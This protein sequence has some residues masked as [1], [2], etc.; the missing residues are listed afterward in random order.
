[1]GL[2]KSTCVFVFLAHQFSVSGLHAQDSTAG[3]P[4]KPVKVILTFPTCG[5]VDVIARTLTQKLT[6]STGQQYVVDNRAGAGGIV[7][8]DAVA[9]SA[10]DGYTLLFALDT[11]LTVTPHLSRNTPFDSQKDFAPI[12]I[13]AESP[14]VVL[15][16]PSAN[17]GS[18]GE[19]IKRANASPGVLNFGSGGS[20]SSGHLAAGLL[21]NMTGMKITH[22]P[23]KGG[24]QVLT[25]LAG[26]QNQMAVLSLVASNAMIKAGKAQLIAVTGTSWLPGYPD[27]PTVAEAGVPGYQ[28]AYWVGLLAPAGTPRP[29][30]VKL[31]DEVQNLK[32]ADLRQQFHNN[33]VE[34]VGNSPEQFASTIDTEKKKWGEV[35]RLND[36]KAN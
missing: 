7:A 1:M 20:G 33:G 4:A 35:I 15:T 25:D 23:Y 5:G 31:R 13:V 9:K 28:A 29:I 14:L 11:V 36:I 27:V 22:V 6:E 26:G 2:F 34:P 30:T 12:S 24:P 17:I 18:I 3:Y 16:S 10:P 19:L 8:A 32:L 21:N